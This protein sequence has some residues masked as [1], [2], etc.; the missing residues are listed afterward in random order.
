MGLFSPKVVDRHVLEWQFE[1]FE[2]LIQNL[3]SGPG[4]PD[5]DLWKPIA[6]HFGSLDETVLSGSE[7]ANFAFDRIKTQCGFDRDTH[8]TLKLV[9]TPRG[10]GIGGVAMIKMPNSSACGTYECHKNDDGT[11]REII[12]IDQALTDNSTN[13]IA[14][15]AHE[16]SHALHNRMREPL[17]VE[18]ELY[19]LLTDLTAIYLGYG[20]FLANSRFEFGQFQDGEIQGWQ[21]KGAGYLPETDM[22][23]AL[24]IFMSI[25]EIDVDSA[26]TYLKP[27]LGKVLL[28]AMKQL[29]KHKNDIEYLKSLDPLKG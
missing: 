12:T 11:F 28:K 1:Q 13:L 15:L 9:E 23:M 21:A 19:E 25:K 2:V 22:I 4:L 8:F 5:S 20:I 27:R 16:L 18:P 24:A 10:G 6:A 3:S 14:T 26:V 29:E 7:L 17:D